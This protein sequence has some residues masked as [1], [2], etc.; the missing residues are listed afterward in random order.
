M[1]R[2]SSRNQRSKNLKIKHVLQLLFLL[3]IS[4]WLLYQLKHTY[5]QKYAVNSTTNN[6]DENPITTNDQ[7]LP[8]KTTKLGRKDL[9]Q[10][11][12]NHKSDGDRENEVDEEDEEKDTELEQ[13]L[14]DVEVRENGQEDAEENGEDRDDETADGEYDEEGNTDGDANDMEGMKGTLPSVNASISVESDSASNQTVSVNLS[15]NQ[16]NNSTNNVEVK[17]EVGK[18]GVQDE[19]HAIQVS[20]VQAANETA[21]D[22]PPYLSTKVDGKRDEIKEE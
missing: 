3:A 13:L 4:I 15:I 9:P 19:L 18:S 11:I 1:M 22:A 2:Q 20:L 21:T 12:E 16:E 10:N 5:D 8:E 17:E 14:E 7:I 6:P